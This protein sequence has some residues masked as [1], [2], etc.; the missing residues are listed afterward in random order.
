[1]PESDDQV[2][3]LPELEIDVGSGLEVKFKMQKRLRTRKT[4]ARFKD[5]YGLNTISKQVKCFKS[6]TKMVEDGNCSS[7]DLKFRIEA[8]IY[9]LTA[10]LGGQPSTIDHDLSALRQMKTVLS[11]FGGVSIQR[12]Q[13][14]QSFLNLLSSNG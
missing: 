12:S 1:M 13:H 3:M 9:G 4:T 10:Q 6:I 8:V 11:S 14:D 7:S 2:K 5:T